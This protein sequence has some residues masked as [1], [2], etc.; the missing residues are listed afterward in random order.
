M[1]EKL[2]LTVAGTCLCFK[3]LLAS[4]RQCFPNACSIPQSLVPGIPKK[5]S[6]ILQLSNPGVKL[7]NT[8]TTEDLSVLVPDGDTAAH[9][10]FPFPWAQKRKQQHT[11]LCSQLYREC[12]KVLATSSLKGQGKACTESEE[13]WK[14]ALRGR[15]C[16]ELGIGAGAA[17]PGMDVASPVPNGDGNKDFSFGNPTQ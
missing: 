17:V 8:P 10:G 12:Y 5:R 11:M 7:L 9:Q 2:H 1:T 14:W 15:A 3:I 13:W 6:V 16:P 4:L